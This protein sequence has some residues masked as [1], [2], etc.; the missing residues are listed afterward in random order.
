MDSYCE[1]D[2]WFTHVQEA[3]AKHPCVQSTRLQGLAVGHIEPYPRGCIRLQGEP[4]CTS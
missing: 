4:M 3:Y 1:M 2:E